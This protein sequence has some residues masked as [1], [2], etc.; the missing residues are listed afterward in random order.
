M[1][2]HGKVELHLLLAMGTDVMR[3]LFQSAHMARQQLNKG[4]FI[5]LT[6]REFD[7][8]QGIIGDV[9][10]CTMEAT[11]VSGREFPCCS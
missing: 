8:N 2:L 11:P 3:V 9:V 10:M 6:R 7:E 4:E 1:N 5:P